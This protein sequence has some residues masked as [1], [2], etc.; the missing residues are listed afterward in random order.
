MSKSTKENASR[1]PDDWQPTDSD[2]AYLAEKL[3]GMTATQT[4]EFVEAFTLY[5]QSA[6]GAKAR[7]ADWSKTFKVHVL[8]RKAYQSNRPRKTPYCNAREFMNNDVAF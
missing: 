7:K 4:D 8:N 5:W 1:I 3:P 2:L 6:A